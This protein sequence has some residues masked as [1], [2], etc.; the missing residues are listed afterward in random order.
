MVRHGS[1]NRIDMLHGSLWR[2]IIAFS[3]PLIITSFVQQ[4]FYLADSAVVGQFVGSRALAAVGGG[5]PIVGCIINAFIGISVGTNVVI[6]R[7]LGAGERERVD[8][9]IRT[10][11]ITAAAGGLALAVAGNLLVPA[12]MTVMQ[13]PHALRPMAGTYLRIYFCGAPFQ[14]LYNVNAAVLRSFGETRKPVIAITAAGAMNVAMNLFFV[15]VMDMGVAGVALATVLANV[16][17][18]T[19]LFVIVQRGYMTK[20]S[21]ASGYKA[22]EPAALSGAGPAALRPGMGEPL[23][24]ADMEAE[25]GL[26]PVRF[27]PAEFR[28]MLRIGIPAGLQAAVSSLAHLTLQSS[29]NSLGATAM[30]A[31]AVAINYESIATNILTAF[32]QAA[33]TF[34]GQNAGAGNEMRCRSVLRWSMLT[35]CIFTASFC[36]IIIF[37]GGYISHIFTP[38]EDIIHLAMVRIVCIFSFEFLNQIIE[39]FTGAFRGRGYSM[40]PAV[41]CTI[42]KCGVRVVWVLTVFLLWRSFPLLML[43]Y[44]AS[45]L[46]T[47]AMLIP[48]YRRMLKKPL[49][50]AA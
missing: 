19:I 7:A 17:S 31:C 14:L 3:L 42:G 49:R 43:S 27:D 2:G 9:Q 48:A 5:G 16:L 1:K 8:R 47:L 32:G 46:V 6:A 26:R 35:G 4:L 37:F 23:L 15:L 33:V 13:I 44:P 11:V 30:A 28:E 22:A 41:I 10:A 45:W 34:T 12:L 25:A 40:T 50:L 38:D 36:M 39:C 21:P 20:V 24:P 29:V 18:S